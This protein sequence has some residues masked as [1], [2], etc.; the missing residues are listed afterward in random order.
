MKTFTVRVS[1][2]GE[3]EA[4]SLE[5]LEAQLWVAIK[6]FAEPYDTT[7]FEAEEVDIQEEE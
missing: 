5:E 6:L 3:V 7:V 1:Y 4:E 2:A